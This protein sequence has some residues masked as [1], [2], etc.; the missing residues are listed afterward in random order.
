MNIILMGAPGA[1]GHQADLMKQQLGLP[2]LEQ[3][4]IPDNI[5]M[6]PRWANSPSDPG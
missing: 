2:R 6:A 4:L 5:R 3:R 1:K